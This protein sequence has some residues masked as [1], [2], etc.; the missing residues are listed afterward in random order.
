[1]ICC[2]NS[3]VKWNET[4]QKVLLRAC[5]YLRTGARGRVPVFLQFSAAVMPRTQSLTFSL[6]LMRCCFAA[7]RSCFPWRAECLS[8]P[9]KCVRGHHGLPA[10]LE[11]GGQGGGV[12]NC[13]FARCRGADSGNT[14]NKALLKE[15]AFLTGYWYRL[16]HGLIEAIH[17]RDL[18]VSIAC[19]AHPKSVQ[20]GYPP[21]VDSLG[22]ISF[23]RGMNRARQA[24]RVLQEGTEGPAQLGL[25]T[26]VSLYLSSA[27]ADTV[28]AGR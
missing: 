18:L 19:P 6:W 21:N 14:W 2:A 10:G 17:S 15:V 4:K 8:R 1:M 12:R 27:W 26:Q 16:V 3:T 24:P 20:V 28:Q 11:S 7:S 13:S 5:Y 9:F 23:W 25:E 22:V